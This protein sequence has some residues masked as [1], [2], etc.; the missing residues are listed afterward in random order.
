MTN[1][2]D[3]TSDYNVPKGDSK[4]LKLEKGQTEFLPVDSPIIGYEYWTNDNKPVRIKDAPKNPAHLPDIRQEDDGRCR[5][6]HFWAFPVIDVAD[7]RV[8]ILE[9]TQ[10]TIQGDIRAYTKNE[11]WGSPVMKYTFTVS[12]EGDGFDTKYTVMANPLSEI[13]QEW[14]DAWEQVKADGFDLTV[15]FEGGDPFSPET[16]PVAE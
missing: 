15:L 4:Y 9:L 2:F 5:V 10:K 8:K 6:S 1:P 12:R 11:K 14:T 7:G 16:A 13:P 3:P